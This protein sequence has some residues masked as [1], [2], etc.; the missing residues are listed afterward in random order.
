[1]WG[2]E[3]KGTGEGIWP[4]VEEFLR[5][6]PHWILHERFKNNNGLPHP[7]SAHVRLRT[8]MQ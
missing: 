3:W 4:A 8:K 7:R 2:D 5:D 6:N 1:M